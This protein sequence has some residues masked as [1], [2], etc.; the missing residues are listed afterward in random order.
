MVFTYRSR[1][2]LPLALNCDSTDCFSDIV[3]R[4]PD[5]VYVEFYSTFNWFNITCMDVHLGRQ[6]NKDFHGEHDGTKR[7]GDGL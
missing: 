3:S 5:E 4:A 2:P 6:Y 7:F 1:D